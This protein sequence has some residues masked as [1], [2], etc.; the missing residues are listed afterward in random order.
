MLWKQTKSNKKVT[1]VT[2]ITFIHYSRLINSV[3]YNGFGATCLT[4]G[5]VHLS[6]I[7]GRHGSRRQGPIGSIGLLLQGPVH[8][9]GI[10]LQ[11]SHLPHSLKAGGQ[12][13]PG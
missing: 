10:P 4:A 6:V 7:F 8:P 1:L 13:P 12:A 11:P 5:G 3:C 9:P 2:C